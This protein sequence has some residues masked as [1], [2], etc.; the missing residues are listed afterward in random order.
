MKR[1]LLNVAVLS[2]SLFLGS[3]SPLHADVLEDTWGIFTDP[4]KLKEG[5]DNTVQAI[6]EA[7]AAALAAI[8]AASELEEQTDRHIRHYLADINA[9]ISNIDALG[10]KYIKEIRS[11]ET[12]IMS[13]VLTAL[14]EVECS[15]IRISEN[16]VGEQILN[17][18]PKVIADNEVIYKL[19]YGSQPRRVF[20]GLIPWGNESATVVINKK[21]GL[22]QF[23]EFEKIE[24]AY[25]KSLGD[26]TDDDKA[27]LIP[28][29]Y[30]NLANLSV[31]TACLYKDT[32]FRNMLMV[33]FVEYNAMIVPWG[34]S[35]RVEF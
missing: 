9:K 14:K 7:R 20:F 3:L 8:S 26:A 6:K 21:E 17:R 23:E 28:A 30:A 27:I 10:D 29:T 16:A 25:L 4:L 24:K 2:M 5:T 18:F 31:K 32:Y 34:K 15:A 19:P 35:I 33:K 13:D 12:Q 11:I 22:K 1:L